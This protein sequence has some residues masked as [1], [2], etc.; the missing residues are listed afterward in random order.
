MCHPFDMVVAGFFAENNVM[1][2]M[3]NHYEPF[4]SDISRFIPESARR[5]FIRRFC[6]LPR[7][8]NFLL[9]SSCSFATKFMPDISDCRTHNNKMAR[10]NT[11]MVRVTAACTQ[12]NAIAG[13]VPAE[14]QELGEPQ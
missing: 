11:L 1:A 2:K 9:T 6:D 5:L 7:N 12:R 14:T 4:S 8:S 13:S 3:V 10:T